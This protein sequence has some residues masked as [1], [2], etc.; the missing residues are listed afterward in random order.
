MK[1]IKSIEEFIQPLEEKKSPYKRETLLKYKKKYENGEKIPFGVK[2][3]L[4]AQGMIAHEGGIHKGKKKKTEL[5]E[6]ENGR[7]TYDPYELMVMFPNKKSEMIFDEM[8]RANPDVSLIH[9][10]VE[11]GANMNWEYVGYGNYTLLGL[12]VERNDVELV[13]LFLDAGSD[14]TAALDHLSIDKSDKC[15]TILELLLKYGANP[16]EKDWN[17]ETILHDI[18]REGISELARMILKYG[19]DPNVQN[20]KGNT[21]LHLAMLSVGDRDI[22]NVLIENGADTTIKNNNGSTYEDI[23]D[24]ELLGDEWDDQWDEAGWHPDDE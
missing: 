9:D 10:L 3:S 14:A 21:P 11:M 15:K 8:H 4:I 6:M 22:K 23:T 19:A 1:H 2:S 24:D 7:K 13:K 12:A 16:N 17:D 20:E 5:Y 18:A